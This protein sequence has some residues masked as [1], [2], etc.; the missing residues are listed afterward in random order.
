MHARI[1]EM[2]A[3]IKRLAKE[4]DSAI[5]EVG[6]LRRVA[7]DI[8]AQRHATAQREIELELETGLRIIALKDGLREACRYI[9][10][11]YCDDGT[12]TSTKG[13]LLAIAD[14]VQKQ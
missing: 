1:D 13:R 12:A 4:R 14:G 9:D 5:A 3:T 6:R 2:S 11:A 8:E 7:L 10:P